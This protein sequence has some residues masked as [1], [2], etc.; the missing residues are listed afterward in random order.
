MRRDATPEVLAIIP[1]IGR[2]AEVNGAP[3]MLA[4]R[5]LIAYTIE[6]A[7]QCSV[8]NRTVVTTDSATTRDLAMSLG[9]EAP[10]TRPGEL[11]EAGVSL[12][13]V[14]QHCLRWLEEQEGYR[15]GIVMTLETSH[16]VRPPGLLEEVI[17]VLQEQQ[18]DSVFTVHEERHAFWHVDEYGEL[19]PISD[20]QSTPRALRRPLYREM[21]GLALA[22]RA[23]LLLKEGRRIGARIGI[24]P[25][26]EPFALVDTQDPYGRDLAEFILGR[27]RSLGGAE[28]V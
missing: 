6:A 5:P 24:V 15:P 17:G 19:S 27:G 4:N 2:D 26:R 23:T 1:V 3:I 16:P 10:F 22:C 20:E 14:F 18:M 8:V 12:D 7:L 21:T 13:Q 11:A 25:L 9:A 28:V